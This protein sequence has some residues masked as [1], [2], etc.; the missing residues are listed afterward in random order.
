[1]PH[2]IASPFPESKI[3]KAFLDFAEPLLG[4]DI[5]SLTAEEIEKVLS[6]ASVVWN[7]VVYDTVHG[8]TEWITRVRKQ[9]SQ[10]SQIT[11]LID[12]L[13]ARKQTRFGH[14]LRLVGKYEIVETDGEWRLRVEADR[15]GDSPH[16][17]EMG[18]VP[19]STRELL[20]AT[21]RGFPAIRCSAARPETFIS[22]GLI[23]GFEAKP[24]IASVLLK[25]YSP[26]P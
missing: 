11:L 4:N 17:P 8:N 16:S 9:V 20:S 13:I 18:N 10:D 26:N 5:G 21:A 22:A 24:L 2:P 7:A 23:K 14:D 25:V 1:M 12:D 15:N 19:I 3:S 6:I